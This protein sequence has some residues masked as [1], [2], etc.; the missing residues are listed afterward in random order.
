MLNKSLGLRLFSKTALLLLFT[1]A[2][3]IFVTKAFAATTINL[4]FVNHIQANL[5]EQ[6]VFLVSPD[7][8]RKVV[9]IGDE[10][11][12]SG[13]L[14]KNVYSSGNAIEHDPFKLGPSPLGPFT[15]G[16]DLGFSLEEWLA[17]TGTGTYM[18]DG[19][20][21]QLDL[22]L[23][24]LVPKGV[25]TVWCSRLTFPPNPQV[26]DRP[27]GAADGSENSFTADAEG[28][29]Q[30]KLTMQPLEPTTRETASLIALAYHSDG[31]TY[32]EKPGDFGYNS[33][34]HIFAMLPEQPVA[35]V[36]TPQPATAAGMLGLSN[37]VWVIVV[38]VIVL[39]VVGWLWYS[40]KTPPS[41][42]QPPTSE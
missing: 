15:I 33:H 6:D 24:K 21:T 22:N 19:A 7:D 13:N 2:L 36:V 25:Y 10:A 8:S 40:K 37:Q 26:V 11:S 35:P 41:T 3:F 30:F 27:C 29:G 16:K 32:G 14:A 34:V 9:R 20:T 5:P 1:I 31:K 28:N 23:Q 38:V 42:P 4:K 18:V 39:L 12:V 17:A